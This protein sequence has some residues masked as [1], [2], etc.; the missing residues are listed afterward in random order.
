MRALA[1][2]LLTGLVVTS[3]ASAAPQARWQRT[4]QMPAARAEVAAAPYRG[5][6]AVV[7]GFTTGSEWWR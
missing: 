2:A 4:P 6:I 3:L 1:A 5:A 7:G